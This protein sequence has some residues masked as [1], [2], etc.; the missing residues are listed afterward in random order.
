M[1]ADDLLTAGLA[2]WASARLV[3]HPGPSRV[4]E[5]AAL[6]ALA[7]AALWASRRASSGC[8]A[9]QKAWSA[10]AYRPLSD[11]GVPAGVLAAPLLFAC[12][13]LSSSPFHAWW[14]RAFWSSLACGAA[15]ATSLIASGAPFLDSLVATAARGGALAALA[16]A[17]ASGHGLSIAA[18]VGVALV[19]FEGAQRVAFGPA[20]RCFTAGEAAFVST[21]FALL[22]SVLWPLLL[23]PLSALLGPTP[24]QDWPDAAIFSAAL[25]LSVILLC[26]GLALALGTPAGAAPASHKQE[27]GRPRPA[28]G[29]APRRRLA[30]SRDADGEGPGAPRAVPSGD[31]PPE[32]L[33]SAAASVPQPAFWPLTAGGLL[34]LVLPATAFALRQNP[35]PWLLEEVLSY[36]RRTALCAVWAALVALTV[37]ALRP[38]GPLRSRVPRVLERKA[39]HALALALFLPGLALDAAFLS[40]AM[41]AALSAFSLAEAARLALAPPIG[42]AL[43]AFCESFR[44]ARDV[45]PLILTHAY[46]LLG[47]AVPVWLEAPGGPGR[48]APLAAFTGVLALGVADS[49]ASWAG[50]RCGRVRLFGGPKT[51]E[52]ALAGAASLFLSLLL[53]ARFAA[54]AAHPPSLPGLALACLGAAVLEAATSQI[55]NLIVPPYFYAMFRLACG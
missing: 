9:S 48:P 46:L 23:G 21:L 32:P 15:A 41:A 47:C 39:F 42:P 31:A 37:A 45:G 51:L 4:A 49:A 33:H 12:K 55:D 20:A 50:R 44:D 16:A 18:S 3:E 19:A 43:A 36:P 29:P 27:A 13:L 5:A 22:C 14:L 26:A 17:L 30:S 11:A 2:V 52:G 35:L 54:P 1:W 10:T 25:C 53:A 8:G 28:A 40:L 38:G 7:F 34:L 24:P 6:V